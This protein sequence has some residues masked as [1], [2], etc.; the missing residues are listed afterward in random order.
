MHSS[1]CILKL[2][3][4]LLVLATACSEKTLSPDNNRLGLEYYPLEAGQFRTYQVKEIQ[5][6]I[7][8]F[9]T[10]NYQLRESVAGTF[11]NL[12]GN[13]SYTI[14]REK[15][16]NE[17]AE[18]KLDSVW[19]ARKSSATLVSVENNVPVIRLV[20]PIANKL[21][22]DANKFNQANEK[23]FE[24]ETDEPDS[25]LAGQTFT[26]LIKVIESDIEE[27]IVNRDERYA[28]YAPEVGLVIR[29]GITLG[30]CTVDCPDQKTIES[31]R[32][33]QQTLIDYGQN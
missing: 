8:S 19:T 11:E 7:S 2:W 14:H 22:W 26:G 32:F 3:L 18:W 31:G 29:W 12:E 4:V 13:T 25:T 27:N 9:D 33:I 30:F 23:W 17:Q 10:L 5:Y 15:R 20:F 6:S 16:D 21:R 1:K 24:Y 28:V